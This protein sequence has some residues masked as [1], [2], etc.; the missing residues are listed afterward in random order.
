M[1]F[2]NPLN[3]HISATVR[4]FLMKFGTVMHTRRMDGRTDG[5]TIDRYIDPAPLEAGSVNKLLATF[6][7]LASGDIAVALLRMTLLR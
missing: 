4:P 1:N 3:H 7:L 5:Q 2:K 6:V